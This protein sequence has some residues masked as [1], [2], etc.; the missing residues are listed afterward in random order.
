MCGL[1]VSNRKNNLL[2]LVIASRRLLEV[3]TLATVLLASDLS[4]GELDSPEFLIKRMIAA[5]SALNYEGVFVY[6]R[7]NQI[8]SMRVLHR[9]NGETEFERLISLSGPR[10][11]VVRK[12]TE[13]QCLFS[14]DQ[15][16]MVG[17]IEP[18][19]FLSFGLLT[20]V[21]EI[22]AHYRLKLGGQ[23]RIAGQEALKINIIPVENYRYAYQLAVDAKHGLL[24]KSAI[25]GSDGKVLEQVQFAN[26]S[27][28]HE[29]P[30]ESFEPEISG[31]GFTWRTSEDGQNA[32]LAESEGAD[33]W[34]AAW[35]PAGF[36][37]RNRV[38]QRYVGGNAPVS[39]LVYSDGLAMVS[40]F[41]EKRAANSAT[42]LRGV[43][44]MG[45]VN[46][47]SKAT[48]GHHITIVG[49]VPEHTLRKIA[50]SVSA[51]E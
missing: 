10:R 50:G 33:N 25:Y 26:I 30:M 44:S 19:D 39:H 41:V 1:L 4:A 48:N 13:V 14:D 9:V 22:A 46:A 15:E 37:M 49:E 11:E 36:E 18:R 34:R 28:G 43:S 7:G 27:I 2:T 8:D 31:E 40:I 17:K 45:A 23:E 47:L 12:G 20:S 29:I 32:P 42:P 5:S 35:L 16:V 21:E 38:M 51:G 24:L 6:Q 3:V